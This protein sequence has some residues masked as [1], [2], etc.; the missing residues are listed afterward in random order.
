MPSELEQQSVVISSCAIVRTDSTAVPSP[1]G[2]ES[3]I[4]N[5]IRMVDGVDTG[6]YLVK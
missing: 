1:A 2:S 5:A 4:Y 3:G 6:T